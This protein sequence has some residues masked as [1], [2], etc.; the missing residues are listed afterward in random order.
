MTHLNEMTDDTRTSVRLLGG[1][2]TVVMGGTA[3]T[4]LVGLPFQI[5]LARSLG[6]VGLGTL[7]VAEALVH[8]MGG[9]LSFGL[10]SLAVRYIP[11]YQI[12]GATR[13]IQVLLAMVFL[14][15]GC[16]G[17]LGAALVMP[18]AG[19]L[20]VGVI[21]PESMALLG[22]LGLLLPI[23]MLSFFLAQSLRGFQEIR[24]M[25]LSTSVLALVCKVLLTVVLFTM[26]GASLRA[27]AW[28]MVISQGVAALPMGYALW[29]L[30]RVLPA[31]DERTPVDWSAWASYAGTNYFA[32]LLGTLVG[33]LDRIVIGALL[34][35][36]AVGILMIVRQLQQFPA[37]F[38]KAVLTVVSPIFAKLKAAGKMNALAHQ[39]HLS[40]DW[41]V[42]MAT[43]LILVLAILPDHILMLYG[44]DFSA[45]GTSLLLLMTF[46]VSISLGTGPVGIL[47]NMTGHHVALLRITVLTSLLV[48]VGYFTLIPV[49]GVAGVGLAILVGD[50]ITNGAGIWLVQKRLRT[51]WYDPRFR[52]WVLPTTAA[53][54]VLFALRPAF[55][56]LQGL[57]AQAMLLVAAAITAYF[58]FFGVNLLAGLHEDDR[59][60]IAAVRARLVAL[61]SRGVQS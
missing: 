1:Q 60:V 31:E 34:G 41:I 49:F 35:P 7:G 28:A 46:A 37:V 50:S 59:E 4:F 38:H 14:V 51:T 54:A 27:Y 20:P 36:A 6:V 58:V 21:G 18:L 40:N 13:A 52:G 43:P 3:F 22:V 10:A 53:A 16:V 61:L 5:Y 24:I 23:S 11:E 29:R 32:G 33:N 56:G 25:V 57:G 42:R 39:L 55:E 17:A 26:Q 45:E 9:V 47:L 19:W 12:I 2:T 15:L 48:F 8:T 44:S 30:V